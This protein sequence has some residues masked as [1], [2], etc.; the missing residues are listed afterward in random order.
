MTLKPWNQTPQDGS[1]P[2]A[3]DR[4]TAGTAGTQ[5]NRK[6][7]RFFLLLVFLFWFSSYIYVPV[8]SPYVEHLGASYL[9]VG[10]VIGVYG[11]MQILLRMPIGIGSDV[12]GRRRSYI[13][14]GLAAS[15]VGCLLFL[16]G[17]QPGWA[18][19]GRAVS[20]VAASAWV[21][22]SIMFADYWPKEE[23]G[24]AMG[25][26]Q[27]TTVAA[28]LTSMLLS[29]YLVDRWG[30]N[31]P[32][33]LGALVAAGALLLALRLPEQRRSSDGPGIR[34]NELVPVMR[35]PQLVRV[36]LLSVM[37][38]CVLFIT[39]FGYTPSQALN[40][41]ASKGDLGWLTLS[42]M[43]PH[44]IATLYGRRLLVGRMGDRGVLTLGFAGTAAFTLLIPFLPSFGALCATQIGNGLMQGLI[45]PLLLGKSVEG[46]HPAKRATAMGFYQAVY[47]LGM[48]GGPFVAGWIS[49]LWGLRGGFWLGAAVA[50]A[51]AGLTRV[52]L[53]E[54]RMERGE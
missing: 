12:T 4:T 39:M 11:L 41:G 17:D 20:G 28:Q 34:L 13:W 6:N 35:E 42:F 50:A 46:I 37:A 21:V 25:M 31:T 49:S 7:R 18:L 54:H 33:I 44:A 2:Q 29:G 10:M 9:M 24:R 45:F 43:L 48:S 23:S 47:A 19:A 1:A 5:N 36:S 3:A 32:F 8:L 30:W 27:F 26:L 14:L 16:G 15:G 40:L 52:W 22:Y 38:H 51:A 53:R